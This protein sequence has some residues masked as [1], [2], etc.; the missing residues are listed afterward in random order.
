MANRII[1]KGQ[2]YEA[3]KSNDFALYMNNELR[4]DVRGI[5]EK[6]LGTQP[7]KAWSGAVYPGSKS[8]EFAT[9]ADRWPKEAVENVLGDRKKSA[10]LKSEIRGLADK[11]MDKVNQSDEW[12]D[13]NFDRYT[14]ELGEEQGDADNT[15]FF[16]VYIRFINDKPIHYGF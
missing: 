14:I 6:H 7:G 3:V 10:S 12:P 16:G 8:I 15:K 2:L 13:L 1:Y 11:F 9:Y 5:V 4:E